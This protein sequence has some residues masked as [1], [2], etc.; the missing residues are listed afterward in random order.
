MGELIQEL[1]NSES[2]MW[3]GWLEGQGQRIVNFPKSIITS[4][5]FYLH[6]HGSPTGIVYARVRAVSDNS[7]LGTLGSIDII[8]LTTEWQWITFDSTSV[9]V[10][11]KQEIRATIEFSGGSVGNSL[12]H[13]WYSLDVCDGAL[14]SSSDLITWVDVEPASDDTIKLYWTVPYYRLNV[15]GVNLPYED[16][17]KTKELHII[18]KNLSPTTKYKGVDGAVKVKI[19]YEPAA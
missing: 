15:K 4:V 8:T 18:L 14:S 16:L 10:P 9:E 6:K 3:A 17:D 1:Q 7:I 11:Y 12:R 19:D 2:G 5:S 13:G